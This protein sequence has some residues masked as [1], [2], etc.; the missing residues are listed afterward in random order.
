MRV[1]KEI[2]EENYNN[3]ITIECIYCLKVCDNEYDT[4]YKYKIDIIYKFSTYFPCPNLII[5]NNINLSLTL[6]TYD[7]NYDPNS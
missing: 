7:L 1:I 6:Y 4:S 2:I 3:V 5:T